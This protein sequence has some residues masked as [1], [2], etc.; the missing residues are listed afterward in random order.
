MLHQDKGHSKT[1][2]RQLWRSKV[3]NREKE[4]KKELVKRTNDNIGRTSST[5]RMQ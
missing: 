5:Y 4:H 3:V 2:I 1:K